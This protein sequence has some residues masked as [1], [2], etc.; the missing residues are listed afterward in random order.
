MTQVGV[1][2]PPVNL[3]ALRFGVEIET[4]T[5]DRQ[6][7]IDVIARC[8]NTH[9]IATRENYAR[10][11]VTELA[12]GNIWDCYAD[13]TVRCARG[14]ED[15]EVR[16]PI[17][18]Y[19][20]MP[21]LCGIAHQLRLQGC[22]SS[23]TNGCGFHIHVDDAGFDGKAYLNLLNMLHGRE[24][25]L[26]RAGQIATRRTCYCKPIPADFVTFANT[27]YRDGMNR[28]DFLSL[29]SEYNDRQDHIG[30]SC[31]PRG[32]YNLYSCM[33]GKG[34]E[35]RYFSGTINP[36][37]MRAYIQFV[38]AL[39]AHACSLSQRRAPRVKPLVNTCEKFDCRVWLLRLG[40]VGPEYAD[41][42]KI[43][44]GHLEGSNRYA[45]GR[46]ETGTRNARPSRYDNWL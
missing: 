14:Q 36:H 15:M 24:E 46:T 6:A 5:P 23:E 42:R 27:Q 7:S 44:C 32:G 28:D 40:M 1:R 3:S 35:F 31:Y 38:G 16:T 33:S 45:D 20:D 18:A 9:G 8:L 21:L 12:T 34:I 4:A 26:Y 2:V 11:S 13:G 10:C 17:L 37:Y 29:V 41:T 25:F 30:R 43:L 19:S 39:T 22:E